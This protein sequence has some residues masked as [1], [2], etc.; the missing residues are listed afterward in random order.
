MQPFPGSQPG[1]DLISMLG[2]FFLVISVFLQLKIYELPKTQ[3]SKV[4]S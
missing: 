1:N 2:F 4:K 3:N